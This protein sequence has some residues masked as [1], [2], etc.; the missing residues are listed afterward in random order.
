MLDNGKL[1]K[2]LR[3]GNETNKSFSNSSHCVLFAH[4]CYK[5]VLSYLSPLYTFTSECVFSILFSIH[6]LH[7]FYIHLDRNHDLLIL[8]SFP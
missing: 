4:G 8:L 1:K 5:V 2:T 6:F 7:F 3:S